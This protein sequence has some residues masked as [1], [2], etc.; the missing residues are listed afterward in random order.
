MMEDD[1]VLPQ[2]PNGSGTSFLNQGLWVKVSP[3]LLRGHY[4]WFPGNVL[5]AEEIAHWLRTLAFLPDGLSLI[6]STCRIA[7]NH[8]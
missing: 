3:R 8:L 1:E 2:G 6:P 5:E 7:R 4:L